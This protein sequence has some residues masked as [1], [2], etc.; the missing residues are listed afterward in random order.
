MSRPEGAH[1]SFDGRPPTAA[2]VEHIWQTFW[3]PAVTEDGRVSLPKLKGELY[4]AWYL[5]KQ[6][7]LVYHHVTGGLTDDPCASAEA[8]TAAADR[9][10]ARAVEAGID[11]LLRKRGAS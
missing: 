1:P 3:L 4:C 5:I 6:A 11:A 7:P 8:I 10:L 2:E 9:H